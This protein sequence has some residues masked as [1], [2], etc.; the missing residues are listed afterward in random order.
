[1]NKNKQELIFAIRDICRNHDDEKNIENHEDG[2][3]N[4]ILIKCL[5]NHTTITD[6]KNL[7]KVAEEVYWEQHRE[8]RML[9]LNK[10]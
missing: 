7:K 9:K 4:K 6:L 8:A 10:K 3:Y 2:L 5:Y 1:M